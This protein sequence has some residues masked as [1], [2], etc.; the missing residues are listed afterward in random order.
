VGRCEYHVHD[1]PAD[2]CQPALKNEKITA[3]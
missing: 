1:E 2:G 3:R